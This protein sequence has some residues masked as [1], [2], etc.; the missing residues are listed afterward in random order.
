MTPERRAEMG[1]PDDGWEEQVC[2]NHGVDPKLV[3]E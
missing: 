1:L 3:L 2:R